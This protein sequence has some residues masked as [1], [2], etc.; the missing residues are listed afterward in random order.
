LIRG[1]ISV[2]IVLVFSCSSRRE[3][4]QKQSDQVSARKIETE[5][6][7][8]NCYIIKPVLNDKEYKPPMSLKTSNKS[9]DEYLSAIA[10][11][12]HIDTDSNLFYITS[13]EYQKKIFINYQCY[14]KLNEPDSLDLMGIYFNSGS[15]TVTMNRSIVKYVR[16][17][18]KDIFTFGKATVFEYRFDGVAEV[19][20]HFMHIIIKEPTEDEVRYGEDYRGI[21][22][23]SDGLNWRKYKE[24]ETPSFIQTVKGDKKF[25]AP[26]LY[27]G[28]RFIPLIHFDMDAGSSSN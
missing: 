20:P 27:D 13:F 19:E 23:N 22:I 5:K 26:L 24:L 14:G 18:T 4:Q 9:I 11:S 12:K 7:I 1:V 28:N 15:H 10:H 16:S 6:K 17:Y 25:E 3:E 8:I 2:T 21:V